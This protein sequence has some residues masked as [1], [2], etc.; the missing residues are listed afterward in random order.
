MIRLHERNG[1]KDHAIS[2]DTLAI[3]FGETIPAMTSLLYQ[4]Q[5]QGSVTV[6]EPYTGYG[7]T[8]KKSGTGTVSLN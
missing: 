5:D 6:H 8:Q 3:T 1:R 2:I 7:A 4:L